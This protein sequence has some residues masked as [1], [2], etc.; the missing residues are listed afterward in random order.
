VKNLFRSF[1]FATTLVVYVAFASLEGSAASTKAW[2]LLFG[3]PVVLWLTWR[4]TSANLN[5]LEPEHLILADA[6]RASVVGAL[7]FFCARTGPIGHPGFD[8]AA[9]FA[10]GISVVAA[11]VAL[12]RIT[13]RGKLLTPPRI[14]RSFD[15][16]IL[17]ALLWG[18]TT[19]LPAI[20]SLSPNS[21]LALDP[22]AIDYATVTSAMASLL[23]LSATTARLAHF[24]RLEF[25]VSDRA[26]SSFIVS[27]VAL[28]ATVPALLLDIVAPDRAV[29]FVVIL[30][31]LFH[32]WAA[33]ARDAR[34]V[35]SALRT[36][37][38]VVAVV[39]P[40]V[41]LITVFARK[42]PSSAP[43][44][45]VVTACIS[46]ALGLAAARLSR[47]LAAEQSRW[48]D[49][50]HLASEAALV[51]D[52]SDALRATLAALSPT[53][54]GPSS[55]VELWRIDPPTVL[56]VDVAGQIHEDAALVPQSVITLAEQEPERTL[57]RDVLNAVLVRNTT[58]RD[59]LAYFDTRK[60]Y[61]ATL[62][63]RDAEP[64]GLLAL[65]QSHRKS[66]MSLEECIA[67]RGL[68]DRIESVLSIT[69]AQAR[70][71]EREL[72][73][74]ST[75]TELKDEIQRL[76][77]VIN[78][79]GTIH[80]RFVERYAQRLRPQLYSPNARAVQFEL[81]RRAPLVRELALSVPPGTDPLGWAALFHLASPRQAGP[82]VSFECSSSDF[83]KEVWDDDERSPLA[84]AETGTWV[85]LDPQALPLNQQE[86][87]AASILRFRAKHVIEGIAP[88][89]V[90]LALHTPNS[91][92]I[93]E[94]TLSDSL[95]ALFL[96]E[97]IIKVAPLMERAEDLR[98]TIYERAA[99]LGTVLRG[100]PLG[101][102]NAALAELLEYEWPGNDLELE[103]TMTSLVLAAEDNTITDETLQTIGFLTNDTAP[104]RTRA[105]GERDNAKRRPRIT[106]RAVRPKIR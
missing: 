20:R 68:C 70:S 83:E 32:V 24:R 102:S 12:A 9:N 104:H 89:G 39:A 78:A 52:P 96:A 4:Y 72:Q 35:S 22:L 74:L 56:Y 8:A 47:P 58:A 44:L 69:S 38:A 63:T 28:L 27:V 45:I 90:V 57:R 26:T 55:R 19:T 59:A 77:T 53:S 21:F 16:A 43:V 17:G 18:L 49:A 41:L 73:A 36:S 85:L 60:A 106:T 14:T 65:P 84:V 37:L 3:A 11:C 71:R 23:L 79:T 103:T 86:I 29:P 10:V 98:A 91:V 40:L 50:I 48:L 93:D 1:W 100:T 82:F 75:V 62:L 2:I 7:L 42:S 76:T 30:T 81:L 105:E 95:K 94:L 51:P 97:N 64:L 66:P 25:E 61:A 15:A 92:S 99:R 87:I 67:L 46:V 88:M 101:V 34:R 80:Q 33:S 31:C 54:P 6:Q 13:G 5:V